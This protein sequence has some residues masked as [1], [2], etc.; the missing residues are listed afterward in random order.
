MQARFPEQWKGKNSPVSLVPLL[1]SFHQRREKAHQDSHG[2]KAIQ[3]QRV[4]FRIQRPTEL[5]NPLAHAHGGQ[6]VLVCVLPKRLFAKNS[7]EGTRQKAP[8][9]IYSVQSEPTAPCVH[10]VR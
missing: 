10:W 3:V 8:L 1:E 4:L 6:A 2:G 9:T 5:E 7:P